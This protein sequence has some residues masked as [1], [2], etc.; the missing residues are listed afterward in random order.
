MRKYGLFFIIIVLIIVLGGCNQ[1]VTTDDLIG[2]EWIAKSGYKDGEPSGE[3]VCPPYNKGI[4]FKDEETVSVKKSVRPSVKGGE[5]GDKDFRYHLRE[6]DD[7]M[8]I[9]F[10]NPNGEFDVFKIS[11][12]SEDQLVLLGIGPLES[13]NCYFER[14]K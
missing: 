3:P 12:E 11:V 6:S 10:Y 4:E 9:E 8:K 2:G 5:R 7:E 1:M 14:E 13:F